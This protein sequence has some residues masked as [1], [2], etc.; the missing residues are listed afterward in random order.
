MTIGIL[1]VRE[2]EGWDN[3]LANLLHQCAAHLCPTKR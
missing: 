1:A 2:I 3:T